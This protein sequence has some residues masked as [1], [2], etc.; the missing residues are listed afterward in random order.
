MNILEAVSLKQN[1]PSF[2]TTADRL[3]NYRPIHTQWIN[4]AMLN[5][6]LISSTHKNS[7]GGAQEESQT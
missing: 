4:N 7:K 2:K 5:L 1:Y 3:D 6:E